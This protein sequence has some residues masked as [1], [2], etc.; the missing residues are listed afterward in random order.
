MHEL[1]ARLHCGSEATAEPSIVGN[2]DIPPCRH[3]RGWLSAL[4]TSLAVMSTI[5][6]MRS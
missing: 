5:S 3:Y 1:E 4:L 2:Q 6:I